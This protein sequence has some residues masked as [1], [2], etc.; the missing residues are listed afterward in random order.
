MAV[1]GAS[2]DPDSIG[3]RLL[4]NL[5][6]PPFAG[7]VHAVNPKSAVVQGMAAHPS[8]SDIPGP[9]DVAFIAVPAAHV[10]TVARE[11]AEKGVRGLVVISAGFAETGDEGASLQRDLLEVCRAS[12]MRLIGPNCMGVVNTDPTCS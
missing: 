4:H 7:V 9:V 8:V 3:G 10:L 1:I 11:C 12:G 5:L 2:R 6:D